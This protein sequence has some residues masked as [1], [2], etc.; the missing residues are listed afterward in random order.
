[1]SANEMPGR[2][3]CFVR[4]VGQTFGVALLHGFAD[5][6]QWPV[7]DC[8]KYTHRTGRMRGINT[9]NNHGIRASA[10]VKWRSVRPGELRSL[11]E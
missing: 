7:R 8:V 1:M 4:H 10:Q 2:R 3:K 6:R 5:E 11:P 9:E